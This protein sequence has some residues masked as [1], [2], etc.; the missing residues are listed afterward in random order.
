MY[1]MTSKIKHSSLGLSDIFVGKIV[2]VRNQ[3]ELF[4]SPNPRNVK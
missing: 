3:G 2:T 1:S 4:G